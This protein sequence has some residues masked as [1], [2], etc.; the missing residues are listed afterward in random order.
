[1]YYIRDC[2]A[3]KGRI[4]D[5]S[6]TQ[7]IYIIFLTQL[8]NKFVLGNARPITMSLSYS[9]VKTKELISNRF[10]N[11]PCEDMPLTSILRKIPDD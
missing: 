8:F 5:A 1:M 11:I 7:S 9:P 3:G 10:D 2:G 4:I 6:N